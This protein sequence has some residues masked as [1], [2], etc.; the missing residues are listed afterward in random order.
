VYAGALWMWAALLLPIALNSS[1]PY[2]LALAWCG[3]GAVGTVVAVALTIYRVDTIPEDTL[4]QGI[5][6]AAIVTN[7]AVAL[8]AL[9]AG[10]LPSLWG[11]SATGWIVFA[12]MLSLAPVGTLLAVRAGSVPGSKS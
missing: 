1:D 8:G 5:G 10:Y 3:S 2:V 11:V 7:G 6:A 12:A 4:G 9:P